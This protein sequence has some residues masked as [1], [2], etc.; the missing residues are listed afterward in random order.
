MNQPSKI[1]LLE[2]A[3]PYALD[4]VTPTE[5]AAIE[6]RLAAAP[7]PIA[8][9]FHAEVR[10]VRETLAALSATTS[11][12]PPAALRAQVLSTVVQPARRRFGWRSTLLAAAAAVAIGLG[13]LGIGLSMRPPATP[14]TAEQVFTAPDV[15]TTTAA[16]S[17]GGTATVV[18]S[19]QHHAGVLVMN[20]P[21][22]PA[23]GTVY[24]M[25]LL[26]DHAPTSAG[27]LGRT[28]IRPS[29]TTVLPDLANSSAVAFTIEPGTGSPQPTGAVIA[30]LPLT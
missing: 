6:T 23:P 10:A 17:T 5:R 18:Y 30:K 8:H 12:E 13:A 16:I 7:A 29:T 25:W 14:S 19:R 24:Q 15:H 21:T 20:N 4:A 11:A 3:T 28:A 26:D 9:A 1:D 22:P 27:T 2:L